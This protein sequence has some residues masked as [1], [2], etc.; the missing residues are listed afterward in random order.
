MEVAAPWHHNLG[1]MVAER[2]NRHSDRAG[3][4]RIVAMEVVSGVGDGVFWVGMISAL[5]DRGAGTGGFA[6]AAVARLGPRALMSLPAGFIAD[7]VDRRRLLVMLD[8]ARAALMVVL[9]GAVAADA[10]IPVLVLIV[11][12]SYTLASPYRPALTAA[13]PAVAGERELSSTN[14]LISTVR[15]LVTFVGLVVGSA[16]VEWTS[17]SIAFLANGATFVLSGLLVGSVRSLGGRRGRTTHRS[18]QGAAGRASIKERW[19]EISHITGL[20]VVTGLVFAMYLARGAELVLHVEVA[21]DR[22]GLGASGVGL[23]GAAVGLGALAALP[24]AAR[25][26]QTTRPALVLTSAVGSTA[27]PFA[28]LA[29]V[30]SAVVVCLGLVV[31]GAGVVVFEVLSVVLL[32]RLARLDTLGGVFGLVHSASNA[33]KLLGALVAP[34]AVTIAG[35]RGAL[36]LTG[37]T[38]AVAGAAAVPGL[39]RLDRATAQR[40]RQLQPIVDVLAGLGLFDSA[41]VASLERIAGSLST[42]HLPAGTVVIRQ[43]DPADDLYVTRSGALRVYDGDVTINTMG[44]GDWFG[45]IGLLN[46]SARTATVVSDGPVELWRIPGDEFLGAL[47]ESAAPASALIEAMSDRLGRS[48]TIAARRDGGPST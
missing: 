13:L 38:I 47:Q 33:G 9:A 12:L 19:S 3:V 37:V 40:R 20:Q 43:G 25:A 16:F 14:A 11:A 39:L 5:L 2:G 32:Q 46:R 27:V 26:A 36:V 31:V 8:L 34:A 44:P 15:Q 22:L 35:L 41:P 28:L 17:S 18:S 1:A 7:R 21:R 4:R 6:I 30:D 45:E 42:A 24:F 48:E 10:S 29:V 23:L